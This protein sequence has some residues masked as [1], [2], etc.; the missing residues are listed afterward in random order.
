[1]LHRR[2]RRRVALA[3]TGC[4]LELARLDAG[5]HAGRPLLYLSFSFLLQS[6]SCLL[7]LHPACVWRRGRPTQAPPAERAADGSTAREEVSSSGRPTGE[8]HTTRR[9]RRERSG[10]ARRP[11]G[12]LRP[13]QTSHVGATSAKT[14]LKTAKGSRSPGFR[15]L[16]DGS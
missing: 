6:F 10:G 15:K 12:G 14:T 2:Q 1:M 3:A 4:E 8:E 7:V 13:N 16:G 5:R 11:A 9:E